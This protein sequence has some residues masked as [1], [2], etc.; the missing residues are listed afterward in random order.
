MKDKYMPIE[1][2]S[3]KQARKRNAR[4]RNIWAINPVTRCPQNPRAY[5]RNNVKRETYRL[6]AGYCLEGRS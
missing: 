3:K 4:F 2:L 6:V 5:R 1:K